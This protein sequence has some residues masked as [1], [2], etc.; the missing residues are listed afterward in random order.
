MQVLTFLGDSSSSR[1]G[2]LGEKGE[3]RAQRSFF[4]R[5]AR[6]RWQRVSVEHANSLE[7]FVCFASKCGNL[8]V[9][10]FFFSILDIFVKYFFDFQNNKKVP[11]NYSVNHRIIRYPTELFGPPNYF[12]PLPYEW[13]CAEGDFSREIKVLKLYIFGFP[14]GKHSPTVPLSLKFLPLGHKNLT[15]FKNTGH[16]FTFCWFSALDSCAHV[17]CDYIHKH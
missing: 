6:E 16:F 8:L 1:W 10:F 14:L 5:I 9:L 12:H 4:E 15:K 2:A 13:G 7:Y 11:P 3:L 17:I